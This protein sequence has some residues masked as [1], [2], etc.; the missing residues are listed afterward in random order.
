MLI[1]S[2]LLIY[3]LNTN[4]PKVGVAREFLSR[5]R[6]K[7]VFSQ[8]TIYETLR[9]VT[10][11]VFPNPMGVTQALDLIDGVVGE[12]RIVCQNERTWLY[13]TML[14]G[15]YEIRGS[16]IFDTVLVATALSNG[17]GQIVTDNVKHLGKYEEIE[18]VGLG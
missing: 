1:D 8:Q 2:N 3:S 16:E 18:V 14:L 15:K 7:L 11:R 10:H 5:N 4:S 9:V 17:V 13:V 12:S 6:A